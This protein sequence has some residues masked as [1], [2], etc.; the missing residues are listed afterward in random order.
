MSKSIKKIAAALLAVLLLVAMIPFTA[1]AASNDYSFKATCSKPGFT[2]TVYQMAT[3]NTTNG[4][5]T[6]AANLDSAIATAIGGTGTGAV[7]GASIIA[8]AQGKTKLGTELADKFVTT[9][10]VTE[11][12]FSSLAGGIYYI[13]AS[14]TDASATVNDSV[15]VLPEY[16]NGSFAPATTVPTVDLATKV[17]SLNVTKEIVDGLAKNY[18]STDKNT[19]V[20]F[21][22]TSTVP[23]STVDKIKSFTILDSM[24]KGLSVTLDKA[25]FTVTQNGSALAWDF[26]TDTTGFNGYDGGTTFGI[27]IADSVISSDAFYTAGPVV[28][29]YS[30]KLTADAEIATQGNSVS[31]DNKDA[32]QFV[33]KSDV[34]STQDGQT[35]QVFSFELNLTKIDGNTNDALKNAVFTINGTDYTTDANGKIVIKGVNAGQFSIKEKTAP[36]GYVKDD[37]TKTVTITPSYDTSSSVVTVSFGSGTTVKDGS[38]TVANYSVV[39][40]QTGGMGTILFTAVGVSLIVLAGVIFIVLKKKSSAK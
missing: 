3:L 33:D 16:V 22:L 38:I 31:N 2:F 5:Y 28:V 7:S 24:E 21:R 30:A 9:D 13:K 34:K 25:N 37:T 18:T 36:T 15:V 12:T 11:K 20:K 26:A 27:K 1:S 29:E 39:T 10:T 4:A 17:G 8:A 40:P 35:V 14:S 32:V 23:G 6:P 19:A